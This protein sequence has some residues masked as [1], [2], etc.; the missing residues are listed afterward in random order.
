MISWNGENTDSIARGDYD[1]M[2]SARAQAVAMLN[3]PVFIR[4]FWEMDGN[5][6]AGFISSPASYVRAW[7]HI[8]D[9]FIAAGATNVAWVW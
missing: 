1:G 9:V 4:W 7:R 5:K 2:I 8:H 6:K 3:T